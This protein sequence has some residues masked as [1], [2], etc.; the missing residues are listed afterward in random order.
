MMDDGIFWQIIE[1]FD[2]TYEGTSVKVTQSAI[3]WLSRLSEAD[4][5]EFDEILV[6]KLMPSITQAHGR[7]VASA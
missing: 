2:W 5:R 4:L 1:S 3:D 7:A 6:E